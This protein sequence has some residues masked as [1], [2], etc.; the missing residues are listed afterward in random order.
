MNEEIIELERLNK[1][2]KTLLIIRFACIVIASIVG[3]R[4]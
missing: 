4:F 3:L 1:K 2:C